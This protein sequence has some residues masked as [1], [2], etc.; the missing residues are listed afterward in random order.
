MDSAFEVTSNLLLIL[1]AVAVFAGFIDAIAG[2]GGLIS[3]PA[4]LIL[5]V[6]PVIALGTNRMQSSVGELTSIIVYRNS[7][8]ITGDYLKRGILFTAL[9][10]VGGSFTVYWLPNDVLYVLLPILMFA[11]LT[12]TLFSKRIRENQESRKLMSEAAFMMLAGAVLGFYNGFFGPGTGSLWVIAFIS[13]AGYTIKN[14]S[15][16]SKPLNFTSNLVSL[17]CFI[18]MGMVNFKLGLAMAAG[19]V[20]GSYLGSHTV[21]NNGDKIVR[22]VFIVI[23]SL[24]TIKLLYDGF[25]SGK[26]LS[27][28]A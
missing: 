24:M 2:G 13:L 19:Q 9:G 21:L 4:M 22:P 14:A 11:I 27:V 1:F 8:K 18:F 5:G 20:I 26:I 15:I 6:P 3:T 16:H 10:A 7:G 12:Y 23:T 28:F 17:A 25:T